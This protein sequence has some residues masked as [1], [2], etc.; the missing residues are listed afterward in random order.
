MIFFKLH[1]LQIHTT[2]VIMQ[3]KVTRDSMYIFRNQLELVC[4]VIGWGGGV[5]DYLFGVGGGIE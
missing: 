4:L 2:T 1:Y 3:K 5:S